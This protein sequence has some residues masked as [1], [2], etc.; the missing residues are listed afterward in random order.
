M[1][2]GAM[3]PGRDRKGGRSM[4]IKFS[5]GSCG[6]KFSAK[7][8][9][10]GRS[11]KCPA[12][13]W[14]ITV[15]FPTTLEEQASP[16]PVIPP[17]LSPVPEVPAAL[18]AINTTEDDDDAEPTRPSWVGNR[19]LRNGIMVG[20][21]V[22][23]AIVPFSVIALVH[24]GPRAM[25]HS[26]ALQPSELPSRV[27][28]EQSTARDASSSGYT[29]LDASIG[30]AFSSEYGKD[31]LYIRLARK[32]S[33]TTLDKIAHEIKSNKPR[34]PRTGTRNL[35]TVIYCYLPEVDAFG[36]DGP[37]GGPWAIVDIN[38][39]VK[40]VGVDIT[41]YGFTIDEEIKTVATRVP[42][43]GEIVGEWIDDSIGQSLHFIVLRDGIY[44][45][46]HGGTFKQELV[47]MGPR[48]FRLF[49]RKEPSK[50]GDYY[51]INERGDLEMRDDHGLIV[52]ARRVK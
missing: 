52:V 14:G 37:F 9:H 26:D 16:E 22:I 17:P 43:S 50:A 32:V 47:G 1:M 28:S 36:P 12:C 41:I 7:D 48:P 15:P 6:R 19:R 11:S 24:S 29:F 27:T 30:E 10:A 42:P 46:T 44:Y 2:N 20:A 8:E 33:R 3:H 4:A 51:R 45:L 34:N 38:G 25:P 39:P 31:V 13:G 18:T 35:R 5:C 49:E 23:C 21:A 40:K